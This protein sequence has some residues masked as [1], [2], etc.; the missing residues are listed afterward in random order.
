MTNLAANWIIWTPMAYSLMLPQ[1]ALTLI[2]L[3]SL[4]VYLTQVRKA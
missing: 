3:V 1:Y 2:T 4:T